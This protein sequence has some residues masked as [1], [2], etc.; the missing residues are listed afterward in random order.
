MCK[1]SCRSGHPPLSSPTFLPYYLSPSSFLLPHLPPLLP[2]STLTSLA[3][4]LLLSH[5][6]PPTFHPHIP[7]LPPSTL[8]SLTSHLPPSH[9]LPPSFHPHIPYLPPPTLTSLTSLL[10]LS[11]PLP[12]SFHSHI[13]HLPPSSLPTLTS[14]TSLPHLH[15][16]FLSLPLS[17]G[18]L[19]FI[20]GTLDGLIQILSRRHNTED[21]IA[22]V[23]AVE[24]HSF[25]YKG[26][27]VCI[28]HHT[29]HTS[30]TH[31]TI[32]VTLIKHATV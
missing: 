10:P 13:P 31:H 15:V 12:P 3:S 28:T 30:H 25:I 11:H 5:P 16:T 27:W 14:L 21:L 17:Q 26:R 1:L 20:C 8:T 6:L 9:P 2:P 7:H 29:L 18:G 23:M 24:P 4:L 32:T 19:V 22:T